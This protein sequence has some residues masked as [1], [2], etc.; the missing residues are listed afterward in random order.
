[1][2]GDER[3]RHDHYDRSAVFRLD[4]QD[5]FGLVE[6]P[7]VI[8]VSSAEKILK[9]CENYYLYV[10]N[11]PVGAAARIDVSQAYRPPEGTTSSPPHAFG[12]IVYHFV[13]DAE[14]WTEWAK[15]AGEQELLVGLN[16]LCKHMDDWWKPVGA[17]QST[18]ARDLFLIGPFLDTKWKKL[19]DPAINLS[20]SK[21]RQIV[22]LKERLEEFKASKIGEGLV[23]ETIMHGDLHCGNVFRTKSEGKMALIFFSFL[24]S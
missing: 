6:I 3:S 21:R 17:S 2:A 10:H 24:E 18:K 12:A 4:V 7:R 14:P 22:E 11:K 20:K 9:E 16:E 15:S 5:A 1:M 8:K 19:H 13:A 23:K